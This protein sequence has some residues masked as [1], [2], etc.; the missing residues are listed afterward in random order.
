VTSDESLPGSLSGRAREECSQHR[1]F[2]SSNFAETG[3]FPER[4]LQLC[5]ASRSSASASASASASVASHRRIDR[6]KDRTDG[7][8]KPKSIAQ[9]APPLVSAVTSC[10]QCEPVAG[11]ARLLLS[12]R[13]FRDWN[14]STIQDVT[15]T[16]PTSQATLDKRT[17][18]SEGAT[19]SGILAS[20]PRRLAHRRRIS[21]F[22]FFLDTSL[23]PRV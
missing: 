1:E 12:L 13:C 6:S 22:F 17:A 2:D 4:N 3:G 9:I 15:S 7:S 11:S 10:C 18:R 20:T 23:P 14:F 16:W 8:C 19:I 5:E 21:C